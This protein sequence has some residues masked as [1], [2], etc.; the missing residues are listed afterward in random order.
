MDI[1]CKIASK[2]IPSNFV[3]EDDIVMCIMDISPI[4]DGHVLIIPKKHYETIMETPNDVL[5]HMFDIARMLAP[6]IMKATHEEGFTLSINYGDQQ[7]IKHLHL[8]LMPNFK[9][10]AS[11]SME[12]IYK[13][14]MEG[15]N[16]KKED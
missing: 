7:E 13:L 5:M 14:I 15:L 3:Y 10:S 2:E 4:C 16:E 9:K 11:K 1:F 8:H 6:T 12:E